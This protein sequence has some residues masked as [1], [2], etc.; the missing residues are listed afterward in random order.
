M[1]SEKSKFDGAALWLKKLTN[2]ETYYSIRLSDGKWI[3]L[4]KNKNKVDG[5]KKPDFVENQKKAKQD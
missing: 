1:E 4:Y 5:D 2:G 3:Q